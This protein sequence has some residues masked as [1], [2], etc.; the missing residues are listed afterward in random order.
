MGTALTIVPTMGLVTG[1]RSRL[2]RARG[3]QWEPEIRGVQEDGGRATQ[4]LDIFPDVRPMH[5]CGSSG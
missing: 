4:R 2:D 3:A 1:I 5:R